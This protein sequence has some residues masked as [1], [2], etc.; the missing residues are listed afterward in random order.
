MA[1][2]FKYYL[3]V[4]VQLNIKSSSMGIYT[5]GIKRYHKIDIDRFNHLLIK[6]KYVLSF[7]KM[8]NDKIWRN[9]IQVPECKWKM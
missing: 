5:N 2:N 4:S 9:A 1:P 7:T 6:M 3:Y 8:H